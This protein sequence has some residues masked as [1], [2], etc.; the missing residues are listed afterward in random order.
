VL[1][2][3][4]DDDTREACATMLEEQG[5]KVRAEA[6]AAGGLAALE[7]F[8]PQVILCDIAMPDEDGYA[9]IRKLRGGHRASET[10]AAALTALAGEEHRKR[11]LESGF[12][13]HLAKPIDADR[14]A[15]AVATLQAWPV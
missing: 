8:V 1:L 15:T 6:S 13:M 12:Q 9:F 2:I 7:E 14:L 3:E 4:D 10:P 5:A 11:V